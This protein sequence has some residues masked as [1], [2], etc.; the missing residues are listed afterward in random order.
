MCTTVDGVRHWLWRAVDEHGFVLNILLQ[1]YR[2]IEAA[3][4]LSKR[5]LAEYDV[6]EVIHADQ[7]R[8]Y[9]AAI[10]ELP[11]LDGV[12]HQQVISTA[13]CN[14]IVEQRAGVHPGVSS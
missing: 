3:K 6:P 7:L 1:R 8:S 9:G 2:D 10:R 4:T 11:S 14:N 13:R 12:D 5:L